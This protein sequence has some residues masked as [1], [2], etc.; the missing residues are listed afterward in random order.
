MMKMKKIYIAPVADFV[1]AEFM[2]IL[3]DFSTFE[4]GRGDSDGNTANEQISGSWSDI[5]GNMQ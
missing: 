1:E 5:W 4:G 3:T 2:P